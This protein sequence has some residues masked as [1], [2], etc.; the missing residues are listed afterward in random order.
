MKATAIPELV[1]PFGILCKVAAPSIPRKACKNTGKVAKRCGFRLKV[2]DFDE[3][4]IYCFAFI[5]PIYHY[6]S[7]TYATYDQF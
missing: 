7:T 3:K 6:K 5:S 1:G 2:P 4:C